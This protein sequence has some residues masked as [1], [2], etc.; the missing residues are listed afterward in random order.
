MIHL[1][2]SYNATDEVYQQILEVNFFGPVRLTNM[3]VNHMIE[4]NK[5]N[6]RLNRSRRAYSIVNI[7][8]VQSYIGTPYRGP[9]TI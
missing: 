5:E 6:D 7:G 1:F 9:C 3:V 8:S 4:D 2:K